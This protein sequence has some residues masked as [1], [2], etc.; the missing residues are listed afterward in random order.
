MD[1]SAEKIALALSG[2]G[3]RALIFHLGVIK[4]LAEKGLL[5][6]ISKISTVSGASLA[7]GLIYSS[8]GYKWP[9]SKEFLCEVLPRIKKTILENNIQKSLVVNKLLPFNWF[10]EQNIILSDTIREV[11]SVDTNLSDINSYPE[12]QINCTTYETGKRFKFSQEQMGDHKIGYTRCDVKLSNALAASAG[13]PVLIGPYKLN[14]TDYIWEKSEFHE[15]TYKENYNELHL[16][17]GGVYDN[18]GIESIF[19]PDDGG[20][21]SDDITYLIVSNAGKK[22]GTQ[23]REKGLSHKNLR[24]LLD[25]ATSQVTA[26]RTRIVIDFFKRTK[27]GMYINMGN[28]ASYIMKD[29]TM[30]AIEKNN[31][32]SECLKDDKVFKVSNYP[33]DL[34]KPSEDTFNMIFK[35][36]YDVT[37]CMYI[38]FIKD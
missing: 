19:K 27:Q 5:E 38:R 33:T 29:V 37:K 30:D 23:F 1:Y 15:G 22:I 20:R 8:N 36:G 10:K 7:V 13:F 4:W 11:W 2:G 12:W 21:L 32:I 28:S 25:I 24:R 35:H 17:D 6:S 14:I 26:L 31:L 3:I 18:L 16:W 34:R 9:T